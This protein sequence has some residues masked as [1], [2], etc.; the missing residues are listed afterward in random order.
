VKASPFNETHWNDADYNELL[1]KSKAALDPA[2]RKKH[3]EAAQ[4]MLYDDGGYIIWGFAN[5]V[6]AYQ[7]YVVGLETSASGYPLGRYAFAKVWIGDVK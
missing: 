4:R 1:A 3:M 7:S 2:Q 6:D 5:N